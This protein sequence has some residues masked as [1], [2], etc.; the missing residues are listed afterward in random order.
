[1][2]SVVSLHHAFQPRADEHN[3]L[4]YLP[5]QLLLDS[6]KLRSQSLCRC[7]PPD[8]KVAPQV[9]ATIVGEPEKRESLRL[10]LTALLSIGR[11]EAPELDQSRL[12]RMD[13][14]TKLRQP[15]LEIPQE[16]L[17]VR[18]VLKPGYEIV[19]VADDD[20]VATRD[21]LSPELDS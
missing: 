4:M 8:H 10:S 5:A 12:F 18:L 9:P 17:C 1:M 20:D 3:R 19:G 14:Q 11:C 13:L 21:F 15:F 2:I 7:P 6:Q 16:P